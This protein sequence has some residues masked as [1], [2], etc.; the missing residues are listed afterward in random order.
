MIRKLFFDK[1]TLYFFWIFFFSFLATSFAYFIAVNTLLEDKVLPNIRIEG[2]SAA[3]MEI[4]ELNALQKSILNSK[5]PD[6]IEF[7]YLDKTV[8]IEKN[9]LVSNVDSDFFI[10]YGK[11]NNFLEVIQRGINLIAPQDFSLQFEPLIQKL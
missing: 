4:E 2:Q 9:N 11:G 10:E 8:S 1:K 6:Q 3:L 7:S 5:L